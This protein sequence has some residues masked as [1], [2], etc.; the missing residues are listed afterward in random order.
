MAGDLLDVH[1]FARQRAGNVNRAAC[2][3]S[4]TVAEVAETL[5]E[6]ALNHARPR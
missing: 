6:Q 2:A 4:D 1:G 5:D 3:R